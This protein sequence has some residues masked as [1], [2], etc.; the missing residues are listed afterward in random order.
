MTDLTTQQLMYIA[1][2]MA[3]GFAIGAYT[4]KK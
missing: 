1:G 2:A 4:A 3:I